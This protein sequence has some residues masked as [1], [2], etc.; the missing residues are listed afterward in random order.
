MLEEPLLLSFDKG[1]D[2]YIPNLMEYTFEI[3]LKSQYKVSFCATIIVHT[4]PVFYPLFR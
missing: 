4:I 2:F 1:M 3:S